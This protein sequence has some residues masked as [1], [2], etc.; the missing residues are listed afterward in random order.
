MSTYNIYAKS[1]GDD[2]TLYFNIHA[3]VHY[4]SARFSA[5]ELPLGVGGH[6]M[7]LWLPLCTNFTHNG[8]FLPTSE[9]LFIILSARH[10][11]RNGTDTN[12]AS[13]G[14]SS[15]CLRHNHHLP[16]SWQLRT[17]KLSSTQMDWRDSSLSH[18]SSSH[19]F[20]TLILYPQAWC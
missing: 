7:Y 20:Q 16:S 8:S 19:L 10:R 11:H 18:G 6:R 15:S 4:W 5:N 17:R 13:L 3:E 9:P 2:I 14:N 12:T 1:F